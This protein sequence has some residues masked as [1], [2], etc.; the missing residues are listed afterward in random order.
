MFCKE[1][2]AILTSLGLGIA[3]IGR[4]LKNWAK[5]NNLN[6]KILFIG[7]SSPVILIFIYQTFRIFTIE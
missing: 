5:W 1:N 7:L 4:T 6:K 2:P 3:V